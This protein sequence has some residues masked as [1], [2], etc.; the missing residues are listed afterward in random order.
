MADKVKAQ[1]NL[2]LW[3]CYTQPEMEDIM[4]NNAI[5]L[6]AIRSHEA[7]SSDA[8]AKWLT[9][10]STP[11]AARERAQWYNPVP[12]EQLF[13]VQVTVTVKG[14]G[15]FT[16]D[17]SLTHVARHGT[18]RFHKD[19]PLEVFDDEN[20]LLLRVDLAPRVPSQD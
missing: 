11:E 13:F 20:D 5:T 12:S 16:K 2:E 6:I 4:K 7:Q 14:I 18:W 8:V 9:F 17:G 15:H 10:R 19:V 1:S 3:A